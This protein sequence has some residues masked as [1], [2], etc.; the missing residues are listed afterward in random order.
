MQEKDKSD[1]LS[2]YKIL[3]NISRNICQD[4]KMKSSN[5]CK[6]KRQATMT[7]TARLSEIVTASSNDSEDG[8][9]TDDVDNSDSDIPGLDQCASSSDSNESVIDG[10]YSTDG[11]VD[12]VDE[13]EEPTLVEE[14]E[15]NLGDVAAEEEIDDS[16]TLADEIAGDMSTI[17]PEDSS[18]SATGRSVSTISN[19]DTVLLG[20]M[21]AQFDP[22]VVCV[23]LLR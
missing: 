19:A 9:V 10:D 16:D 18:S 23:L 15:E 5:E 11:E 3:V 21:N 4:S 2:A 17:S 12:D 7:A 20:K 8:H 1:S 22:I 13:F 14:N 6:R